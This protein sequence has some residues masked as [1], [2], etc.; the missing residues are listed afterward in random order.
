MKIESVKMT[1]NRVAIVA[2]LKK[3]TNHPTADELFGIVKKHYPKIS[4]GTLYR[5]LTLLSQLGVIRKIDTGNKSRFDGN[6]CFHYHARCIRC[7]RLIDL[8]EKYNKQTIVE[9]MVEDGFVITGYR[10]EFIGICKE[11]IEDKKTNI[12]KELDMEHKTDVL[13]SEEKTVLSALAGVKLPVGTK[14]IVSEAK[15]ESKLVSNIIKKLKAKGFI[16]SPVRCKYAITEK[17]RQ[18]VS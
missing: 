18:L 4:L 17:G 9:K 14:D 15:I 11:C 5:N 16:E 13:S 2:E 10:L 12:I 7:G 1:K 3:L 8:P 6:T